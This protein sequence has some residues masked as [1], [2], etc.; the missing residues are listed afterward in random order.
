MISPTVLDRE[1]GIA[2]QRK[3]IYL[4]PLATFP[5][6]M[7]EQCNEP[8]DRRDFKPGKVPA[9]LAASVPPEHQDFGALVLS[10]GAV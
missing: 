7:P 9:G 5:H 2:G 1:M 4:R 6:S 3:Q 10:L 8:A